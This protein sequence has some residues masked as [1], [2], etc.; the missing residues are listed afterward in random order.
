MNLYRTLSA[1]LFAVRCLLFIITFALG[2]PRENSKVGQLSKI[3]DDN[4]K[5]EVQ[6][7]GSSQN[8]HSPPTKIHKP[9]PRNSEQYSTSSQHC[10]NTE[11]INCSELDAEC[12]DCVFNE[13]CTYGKNVTVECKKKPEVVCK[14]DE[15]FKRE[16]VC[17]YCYQTPL[18]QQI[19]NGAQGCNS[20]QAPRPMLKH[21]CT[22][23]PSVICL[24][25]RKFYR[26]MPCNWKNG[27][28]WS[29]AFILSVT[30]GGF[31]ADR[32]YLGRWQEGIGKLFSFGGIGLWTIIDIILIGVRYLG[33][34]DGSL[35]VD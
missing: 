19:C 22:V 18:S 11:N 3:G 2:D 17:Q 27:Y 12:I 28:R 26:M 34:A 6:Q 21:N 15:T 9:P 35:Y 16:M 29:T 32:F 5:P 14:A 23:I 25:S 31:G 7:S 20:I 4:V 1:V 8:S 30:L 33:P 24:G 10:V 13:K